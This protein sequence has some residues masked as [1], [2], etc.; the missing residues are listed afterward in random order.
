MGGPRA[1]LAVVASLLLASCAP[2]GEDPLEPNDDQGSPFDGGSL[3]F[4]LNEKDINFHD[5]S[6]VDCISYDIPDPG[7]SQ[8]P[9]VYVEI[10]DN[11]EDVDLSLTFACDNGEAGAFRCD[12][13]EPAEPTCSKG[14]KE[15]D[16][17]FTYDCDEASDEQLGDA[18][19][20][21]CAT[22]P[23]PDKLCIDYT[24]RAYLN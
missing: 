7:A 11:D 13:E 5:Q 19:I 12:G 9:R 10:R 4:S 20:V 6:D 1:A 15:P 3:S 23:G 14:G 22:R 21:I 8:D 2:C 24:V 17:G 18:S 16:L